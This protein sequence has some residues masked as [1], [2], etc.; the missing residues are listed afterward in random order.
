M[1]SIA[2]APD[3]HRGL[4]RGCVTQRGKYAARGTA[5]ASSSLGLSCQ[6]NRRF[7]IEKLP[8]NLWG[9]VGLAATLSGLSRC[10]E[11]HRRSPIDAEKAQAEISI[12]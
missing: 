8:K 7:Q 4:V 6:L 12:S 2:P 11:I 5:F 9:V 3:C 10:C 1:T